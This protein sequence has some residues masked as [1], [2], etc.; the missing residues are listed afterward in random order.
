MRVIEAVT[1][2]GFCASSCVR[3]APRDSRTANPASLKLAMRALCVCGTCGLATQIQASLRSVGVVVE[4][5]MRERKA[6]ID[7]LVCLPEVR[8]SKGLWKAVLGGGVGEAV[9][10]EVGLSAL[11]SAAVV[12]AFFTPLLD[13][14]TSGFFSD[15]A[16]L[17][18]LLMS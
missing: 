13:C 5:G 11:G 6:S 17:R 16:L 1:L 12:L 14:S 4:G 7:S 18:L 10:A 2:F 9:T 3:C 8:S 15:R